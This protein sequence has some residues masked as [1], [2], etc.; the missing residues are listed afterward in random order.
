MTVC[1]VPGCRRV[2][3]RSPRHSFENDDVAEFGMGSPPA[4]SLPMPLPPLSTPLPLFAPPG[5]RSS[6]A[7]AAPSATTITTATAAA[8][9]SRRRVYHQAARSERPLLKRV[10]TP[11][12]HSSRLA[13]LS[14]SLPLHDRD[15][16]RDY[17]HYDYDDDHG[18]PRSTTTMKAKKRN[19][20]T[21]N[22]GGA[23]GG[24]D[25]SMPAAPAPA[26]IN[27]EN[28]TLSVRKQLSLVRRFQEQ[29]DL[30]DTRKH[31]K[32]LQRTSFRR[33]KD[34]EQQRRRRRNAKA[35]DTDIPDGKYETDIEPIIFVDGYNVI[36]RWPRLRKWRDRDDLDHARRLLL[37]DV[38]EFSAI[39]G[40]ECVV[41]F[42]AGGRGK[43]LISVSYL[44]HVG[45][46]SSPVRVVQQFFSL[47]KKLTQL[48][49]R[50][51]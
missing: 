35:R 27:V 18:Q 5:F 41:V 8:T 15:Y 36:G 7:A 10:S 34:D 1:E 29:Q 2:L 51:S 30:D 37:D 11:L 19:R 23:R 40:W 6:P 21:P 13:S 43:W 22:S 48:P 26:R 46:S 20:S 28:T 31:G 24:G 42:D 17:Y 3:S 47:M 39:R 25:G 9:A 32:P 14:P 4:S 44:F 45:E 38:A 16:Y 12:P 33:Q 49:L 50:C